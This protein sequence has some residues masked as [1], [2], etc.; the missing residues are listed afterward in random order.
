MW[1]AL[2][3]TT[4]PERSS[5]P[6][7]TSSP[8]TE[9][10]HLPPILAEV[11]RIMHEPPAA[12]AGMTVL[13]AAHKTG[14]RRRQGGLRRKAHPEPLPSVDDSSGPRAFHHSPAQR[15]GL[16]LHYQ[17]RDY[18]SLQSRPPCL[19]LLVATG[20]RSHSAPSHIPY[21][22]ER[23]GTISTISRRRL[24][25]NAGVAQN[26]LKLASASRSTIMV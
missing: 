2:L 6:T 11:A 1:A 7:V 18:A 20:S 19:C 5:S 8:T 23:R 13:P 22:L 15:P 10:L 14:R 9:T 26:R 3:F 24:V 25:H 17:C 12:T 16:A 4:R 21:S